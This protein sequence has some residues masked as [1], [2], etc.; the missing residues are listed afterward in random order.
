[1]EEGETMTKFNYDLNDARNVSSVSSALS[2]Q[3]KETIK[4]QFLEITL[5][6]E[7]I[8]SDIIND[9]MN[10]FENFVKYETLTEKQQAYINAVYERY[11]G[12]NR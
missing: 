11:C 5:A 10:I 3:E 9:M 7:Y 12:D 1:V 6:E 8:P 2:S 4:A